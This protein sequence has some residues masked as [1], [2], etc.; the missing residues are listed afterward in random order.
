MKIMNNFYHS[1]MNN[2]ID[3]DDIKH[4]ITFLKSTKK[5]TNGPKVK[6]FEYK[7][8]KWLGVKYSVFVNSGSSAN[9][10]S[11]AAL[12]ILKGTGEIIVPPLT[13]SSDIYAVIHNG[14]KPKFIDIN[15]KNLA[16]DED[17]L[18]KAI[19]KNT[20]ALFLTH[21]LGFN[22]LSNKILSILKKR[23]IELI[24][25]CCE[26]HGAQFLKKKI[27]TFGSQSNFSFYYAHHMST[28][29]G[30]MVCTNDFQTY[31]TLRMLRSHGMVREASSIYT[32]KKFIKK[33]PKLNKEFI[34]A[35]PAYNVRSTEINACLGISQLKKLDQ[36]NKLRFENFKFFLSNLDKKKFYTD[37]EIEGSVNYALIILINKKYIKSNTDYKIK[38]ILKKNKIEFRQGLSGG[39]NQMQQPYL[40]NIIK[41]I[42]NN[43]FKNIEYIHHYGY[44]IGNYPSLKKSRIKKICDIL[45][46]I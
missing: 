14:F 21:V 11:I 22:G 33:Y 42:N 38:S 9:L 28:I 43:N 5:F 31:E 34:F 12:K 6:E 39:G 17:K 25:D 32:K 16:I 2:N 41:K 18:E 3:N 27:G 10:I 23:N 26:S 30:G 37:F 44:Y 4:L 45:N 13:W 40:R 7:W 15:L 46:R 35:Y 1:L 36:N 8:S 20:K 19:N 24:E 29:E